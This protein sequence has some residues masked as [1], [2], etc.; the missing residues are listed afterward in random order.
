MSPQPARPALSNEAEPGAQKTVQAALA[1]LLFHAIY[2]ALAG[3][4]LPVF[5]LSILCVALVVGALLK[6]ERQDAPLWF[7][8]CA[9]SAWLLY[10]LASY[11][12][13]LAPFVHWWPLPLL[14]STLLLAIRHWFAL[15]VGIL[16]VLTL[17]TSGQHQINFL[18][19]VGLPFMTALLL[20]LY[21]AL[22]RHKM[23][24]ALQ[25][26]LG[27]DL[28][29]GCDNK[30]RLQQFLQDVLETHQRYATPASV[31]VL[32]VQLASG[33]LTTASDAM[34]QT[35]SQIW[36]SRLR[37]T[38]RLCRLSDD[39]FVCLLSNTPADKASVVRDDLLKAAAHYEF[40]DKSRLRL[41]SAIIDIAEMGSPAA[42]LERLL[43]WQCHP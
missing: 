37:A 19:L 18:H 22:A 15:A 38:D 14:A 41:A 25:Q 34:L 35:L 8:C 1:V 28:V 16:V 36:R 23:S 6:S 42:G 9:L 30:P 17:T 4:G 43:T 33:G 21:L 24:H 2:V 13:P 32:Q 11:S 5:A 40:A 26:A 10:L 39:R 3:D 7:F 12:Q 31:V 20:C 29:T 27:T